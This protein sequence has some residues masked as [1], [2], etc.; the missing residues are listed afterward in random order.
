[1]S[2]SSYPG[3]LVIQGE[4]CADRHRMFL[5]AVLNLLDSLLQEGHATVRGLLDRPGEHTVVTHGCIPVRVGA[6]LHGPKRAPE[7]PTCPWAPDQAESAWKYFS[8][9][10][11]SSQEVDP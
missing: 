2:V 5:D 1:M 7:R 4:A 11:T 6:P 3:R 9:A 10:S 8:S